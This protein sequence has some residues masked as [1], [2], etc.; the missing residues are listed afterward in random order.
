MKVAKATFKNLPLILLAQKQ[1]ENQNQ[2]A[3]MSVTEDAATSQ[4]Q[5][6]SADQCVL[7]H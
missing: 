4:L 7:L 1:G 5:N 6:H 2:F 3:I